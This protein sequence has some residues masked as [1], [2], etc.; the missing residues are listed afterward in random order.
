MRRRRS[1]SSASGI[2][3]ENGRVAVSSLALS[4][5]LLRR[6]G[7]RLAAPAA[8]DVRRMSRRVGQGNVSGMIVLRKLS[9]LT[10][11]ET[12]PTSHSSIAIAGRDFGMPTLVGALA[13]ARSSGFG[14]RQ[15]SLFELRLDAAWPIVAG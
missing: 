6:G 14:H 2:F 7:S 10:I 3:T 5:A 12:C 11:S 1:A 8:A 9:E 4:A 13:N 15:C